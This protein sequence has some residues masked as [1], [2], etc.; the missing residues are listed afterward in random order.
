MIFAASFAF[1]TTDVDVVAHSTSSQLLDMVDWPPPPPR[2]QND[3]VD[4]DVDDE[5]SLSTVEVVSSEK[6]AETE[7]DSLALQRLID[8][9]PT[10]FRTS[11]VP[12]VVPDDEPSLMTTPSIPPSL[13]VTEQVCTAA[14]DAEVD[15]VLDGGS[16]SP[17]DCTTNGDHLPQLVSDAAATDESVTEVKETASMRELKAAVDVVPRDIN[18]AAARHVIKTSGLDDCRSRQALT[19]SVISA[20]SG[21]SSQSGWQSDML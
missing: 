8:S 12:T 4:E 1:P 7:F 6:T 5:V 9:I 10:P 15:S 2:W 21:C 14:D 16:G 13:D 19:V 20:D 18:A 3:G 17:D 11:S